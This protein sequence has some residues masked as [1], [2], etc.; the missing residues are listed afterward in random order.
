MTYFVFIIIIFVFIYYFYKYEYT[1]KITKK[2]K[3]GFTNTNKQKNSNSLYSK[4]SIQPY[5]LL[6]NIYPLTKHQNVTKNEGKDIWWHYP[7]LKESSFKQVTNNLKYF[8]NPDTGKCTPAE[9]CGSLYSN[10][11][12][13][14]DIVLPLKPIPENKGGEG[15]IRVNYY[16]TTPDLLLGNDYVPYI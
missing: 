9:F 7:V 1:V 4:P 8:K 2:S 3:E 10:K 12:V 15:I 13:P 6:F 16:N 14:S 11:K 5:P